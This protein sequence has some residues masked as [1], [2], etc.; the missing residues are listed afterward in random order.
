MSYLAIDIGTSFIKGAILDTQTG[1]ITSIRRAAFPEPVSGLPESWVE[2]DPVAVSKA[3]GT[4]VADLGSAAMDCHGVL[5]C[6]QM[7]GVILVDAQGEPRTNYLSWRDQRVLD[8]ENNTAS[9][10]FDRL[11]ERLGARYLAELGNELRPGSATS[12]LFWLAQR[13]ARLL[14]RAVPLSLPAFVA[15]QLVGRLPAEHPT[16]AIGL[17]DLHDAGA[18]APVA[19]WHRA[20]FEALGLGDLAWPSLA[21]PNE[22]TGETRVGGKLVPCCPAVG[23]HQCAL[24]GV[25]LDRDELSINVSTGSQVSRLCTSA[26][27]GRYQVRNYFDGLF[28]QTITHLPAGR[29]LDGLVALLTEIP[30][31]AGASCGDVWSYIHEQAEAASSETL[32]ADISFFSGALGD[33]GSLT[34]MRLENLT[35]GHLFRAAF[36]AMARNYAECARRLDPQASWRRIAFSGG[37]ANRSQLLRASVLEKLPGEYRLC[38]EGEDTL[39]GMLALALVADRQEDSAIA[40]SLALNEAAKDLV[41]HDRRSTK[42][43]LSPRERAG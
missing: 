36:Q 2:I 10:V 6:G 24:L 4:L 19:R 23:D 17:L 21:S 7:G 28:L 1:R 39:L 5:L 29:S 31:A 16:Q 32:T 26:A 42:Q 22:A 18:S 30:R 11:R 15:G 43:T 14:N 38:A 12:L 25:G 37:L 20:A 34:G 35:V 40:A 9:T 3:V 41:G 13:D 33:Q 27:A 8:A